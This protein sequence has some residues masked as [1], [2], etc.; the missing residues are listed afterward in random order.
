MNSCNSDTDTD[1][2][3]LVLSKKHRDTKKYII[4][5]KKY[6]ALLIWI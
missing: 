6:S 4:T 2:G 1:T 5:S 3:I